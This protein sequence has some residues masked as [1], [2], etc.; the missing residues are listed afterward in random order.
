MIILECS[1]DDYKKF[2]SFLIKIIKLVKTGHRKIIIHFI[3]EVEFDSKHLKSL[4]RV[5]RLM[6]RKLIDIKIVVPSKK[7]RDTFVLTRLGVYS[8]IFTSLAEAQRYGFIPFIKYGTIATAAIFVIL[9]T[10]VVH[11]LIFS[12][13]IDPYY[14][15]G[16]M[17][18]F[19]ALFLLWKRRSKIKIAKSC[20]SLRTFFFIATAMLFYLT[21]HFVGVNFFKGV[22]LIFFLL[23]FILLLYGKDIY[24]QTFLPIAILFFTV[25]IPRIEEL[26]SMLQ[27]FSA[28]WVPFIVSKLNVAAYNIGINIFLKNGCISIDAPCSGLRSLIAL[29]FIATVFISFLKMAFYKKFFLFLTVVPISIAANLAR[30]IILI[31]I[32]N[33]YGLKVAMF[34]FHYISGLLF[35]ILAL[36]MLILEKAVLR[37]DWE[38]T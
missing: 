28:E 5:L 23:G 19:V 9:Y 27:H 33:G 31:L 13:C 29:L 12:W 11:W 24:Q 15:H 22:S 1:L 36:S 30:I 20:F 3:H 10:Q 7:M 4:Y 14:S 35:F 18:L 38:I 17:V 34:Y 32:A 8:G 21:G 2:N 16:F 26:A 25:P 6:R 37:C